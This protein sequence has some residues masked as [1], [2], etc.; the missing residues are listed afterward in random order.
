MLAVSISTGAGTA[1]HYDEGD[2]GVSHARL[3]LGHTLTSPGHFYSVILVLQT[4]G[5][6]MLPELG[7]EIEARPGDMVFFLANQQLYKLNIDR[8]TLDP[9]QIVL[10]LWTSDGAME[11]ANPAAHT[12]A[13]FQPA[14]SLSGEVDSQYY[15]LRGRVHCG[16]APQR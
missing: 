14:S 16:L 12:H 6:L 5:M 13:D 2:D 3:P 4:G 8:S 15:R 7:Y 10:T 11:L 1:F 9:T